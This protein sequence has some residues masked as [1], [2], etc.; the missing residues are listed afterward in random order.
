MSLNGHVRP[1]VSRDGDAVTVCVARWELI[2][3][4]EIVRALKDG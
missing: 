2:L 1:R 4:V 3:W